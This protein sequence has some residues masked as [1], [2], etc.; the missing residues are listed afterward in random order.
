MQFH[1][2]TFGDRVNIT[3]K[4]VKG[5]E[6]RQEIV[7]VLP[8]GEI[9]TNKWRIWRRKEFKAKGCIFL[10][11]RTI[12]E[13]VRHYENDFGYYFEQKGSF[14]VALVCPGYM[15]NPIYVPV[16]AMEWVG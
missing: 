7:G 11:Y 4:Y 8:K 10:G 15:L 12:Q 14:K 13:G 16:Y 6:Q 3:H 9:R 2:I 5:N 1:T